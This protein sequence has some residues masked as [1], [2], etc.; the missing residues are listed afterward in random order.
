MNSSIFTHKLYN[1]VLNHKYSNECSM[2]CMDWTFIYFFTFVYNFCDKY[3][4][5]KYCS[6]FHSWMIAPKHM[7]CALKF[8]NYDLLNC[9]IMVCLWSCIHTTQSERALKSLTVISYATLLLFGYTCIN[10]AYGHKANGHTLA[11]W[12]KGFIIHTHVY[13]ILC[14]HY[15]M[16]NPWP[17]VWKCFADKIKNVANYAGLNWK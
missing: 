10:V 12:Y 7:F 9:D 17:T 13:C 8:L 11:C 5:V 15:P 3:D 14:I 2:L 1:A 6:H 4:I 16:Y